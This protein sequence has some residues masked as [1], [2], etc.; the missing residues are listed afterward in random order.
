VYAETKKEHTPVGFVI[1]P[2]VAM[3]FSM[4]YYKFHRCMCLY[5][6]QTRKT[7]QATL[8]LSWTVIQFDHLPSTLQM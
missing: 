1:G 5:I 6:L 2:W 7:I 8:N 4:P 3:I